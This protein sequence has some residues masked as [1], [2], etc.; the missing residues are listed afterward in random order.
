MSGGE[1]SVEEARTHPR[2][3]IVTRALGIEPGVVVDTWTLAPLR[4]DRYIL[5]S[6]GLVDEVTDEEI[7]VIAGSE[8]DPQPVAERLVALAN[9]HGGRD[10]VTVVVVDVIDGDEFAPPPVRGG[11]RRRSRRVTRRRHRPDQPHAPDRGDRRRRWCRR[12]AGRR[13][14]RTDRAHGVVGHR[15]RGR[16]SDPVAAGA[17]PPP[18]PSE[19]Y[20][21]GRPLAAVAAPV[22]PA[23]VPPATPI[24]PPRRRRLSA[25][26]IAFWAVI[27]AITVTVIVVI[28]L[29]ITGGDDD[30]APTTRPHRPPPKRRRPPAAPTTTAPPSTTAGTA[31]ATHRG[32]HPTTGERDHSVTTYAAR[33]R[34]TELGLVVMAGIIT[35]A[36]YVLASLGQNAVIPPR[37]LPFLGF[38]LGLLLLAHLAVRVLASRRRPDD[39]AA[40]RPAQRARLRDDHPPVRT[41]RRAAGDLDVH[42]DRHV[43][44]RPAARAT[45]RRPR[46]LPVD[47]LVPRIRAA[48]CCR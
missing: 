14:G 40:R 15:R 46:P 24:T 21:D 11:R 1:I 8:T 29:A 25:A 39:A 31:P 45:R 7:A 2:R 10:N 6:D 17:L 43:R 44:R 5:C 13:G 20:V 19:V 4:G 23:A 27:A 47:V 38:L 26:A 33:R 42:R 41:P 9:E 3:N 12:R 35:G 36:A 48:A 22:P 37:I 16:R 34:S 32:D 30:P 28:V 18:A